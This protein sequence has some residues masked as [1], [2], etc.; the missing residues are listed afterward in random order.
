MADPLDRLDLVH[1]RAVR[2]IQ[3]EALAPVAPVVRLVRDSHRVRP[4]VGAAPPQ[5]LPRAARVHP[6]GELLVVLLDLESTRVRSRPRARVRAPGCRQ[7]VH[8]LPAIDGLDL[9]DVAP[10]AALVPVPPGLGHTL[11]AQLLLHEADQA[12]HPARHQVVQ[13][14]PFVL[15]LLAQT[16]PGVEVTGVDRLDRPVHRWPGERLELLLGKPAVC[17]RSLP[18]MMIGAPL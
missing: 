16:A 9:L 4:A 14:A 8:D 17:H 3:G 11:V 18:S 7:R 15:H 12:Q 1:E 10:P 2:A 6:E 13:V 5:P